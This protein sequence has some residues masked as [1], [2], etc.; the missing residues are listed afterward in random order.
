MK[1]LL[2]IGG[3]ILGVIGLFLPFASVSGF[4]QSVSVNYIDKDGS[5]VIITLI[6]S[7]I[8]LLT[9]KANKFA[10]I[11]LIIGLAITA[12]DGYDASKIMEGSNYSYYKSYITVKLEIGFY[13]IILGHI[14]A[15]VGAIMK[16]E[17]VPNTNVNFQNGFNPYQ[18][19]G[20]N[21]PNQ[22]PMQPMYNPQP[23]QPMMNNFPQQPQTGYGQP[24]PPMNNNMGMP[25]QQPNGSIQPMNMPTNGVSYSWDNNNNNQSNN[26]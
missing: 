17:D 12:Y 1:K 21:Q 18:N 11:P 26:F 9:K 15:C 23:Q 19:Y 14:V 10:L 24:V 20:M 25:Q 5:I 6:V 4:G 13:L 16:N 2:S 22:V 3:C 8:L 7:A